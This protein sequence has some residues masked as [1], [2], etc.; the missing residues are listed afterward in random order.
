[1]RISFLGATALA[2]VLSVLG[3]AVFAL[4]GSGDSAIGALDTL[5][6][7]PGTA[8]IPPT[9]TLSGATITYS[10]ASDSSGIAQVELW[11]REESGSWAFTGQSDPAA[12]SSFLYVPGATTTYYFD[13]VGEDTLGNRSPAPSGSSGT[14]QGATMFTTSV[15]DWML[16]NS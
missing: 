14:G 13:L 12:S 9:A 11:A 4:S 8:S 2:L 3:G 1:M 7:N 5:A 15:N 16:L 10:G 6:P